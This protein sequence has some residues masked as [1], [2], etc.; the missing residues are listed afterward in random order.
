MKECKFCGKQI[1]DDAKK[2]I[3]CGQWL[4]DLIKC[5]TC[6]EMI[7]AS[8]KICRFCKEP[9]PHK[10]N[11]SK[12]KNLFSFKKKTAIIGIGI[13]VV[14]AIGLIIFNL[15]Y[16]P[17]CDS[18]SVYNQI[19]KQLNGNSFDSMDFNFSGAIEKNKMGNVRTCR[20][21]ALVNNYDTY[22]EYK[23]TKKSFKLETTSRFA[24][25]E[26][27]DNM[28]KELAQK[29]IT[30]NFDYIKDKIKKIDVSMVEPKGDKNAGTDSEEI[31]CKATA[32][33]EYKPGW[34]TKNSKFYVNY[35]VKHCEKPY[36]WCVEADWRDR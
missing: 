13:G 20:A 29:I 30:D 32:E 4:D 12:I 6:G 10:I 33:I 16:L 11:W 3:Y 1:E 31:Y 7:N 19:S 22:V 35:T 9:V 26:C 5:P 36:N 15:T 14:A 23:L 28:T 17:P 21:K 27:Y 18:N 8:A 24:L 34:D 2:C 25:P